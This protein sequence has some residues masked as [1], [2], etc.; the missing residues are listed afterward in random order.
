MPV[1]IRPTVAADFDHLV[2]RPPPFR[3]RALT[4]LDGDRVL[5][6]GGVALPPHGTPLAFVE[7]APDA[8]RYAI[9]FHRAGLLAMRMIRDLGLN[10]VTATCDPDD[11]AALRWLARLGFVLSDAQPIDGRVLFVWRRGLGSNQ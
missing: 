5:G 4:V 1:T 7:Q 10:E 11:P 3:L 2:H 8:K 9:S 6:I